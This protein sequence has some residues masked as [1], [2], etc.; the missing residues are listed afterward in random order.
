MQNPVSPRLLKAGTAIVLVA[1]QPC[2][3][4]TT[5]LPPLP[6]HLV[7]VGLSLIGWTSET[8]KGTSKQETWILIAGCGRMYILASQPSL[9]IGMLETDAQSILGD[10][11]C[12][13]AC[14]CVG[15][16][17]RARSLL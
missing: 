10:R 1:M 15:K 16:G 8:V 5:A 4:H 13:R 12:R 3:A 17:W 9:L 11:Q 6:G 2:N 7:R 14:L